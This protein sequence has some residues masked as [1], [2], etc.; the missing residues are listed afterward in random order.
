MKTRHP[1]SHQMNLVNPLVQEFVHEGLPCLIHQ[2]WPDDA[3]APCFVYLDLGNPGDMS[4]QQISGPR[5]AARRTDDRKGW[6]I[7]LHVADA[8]P[9]YLCEIKDAIGDKQPVITTEEP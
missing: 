5:L 2:E 3:G 9:F 8:D 7:L 1:L 4:T 6:R